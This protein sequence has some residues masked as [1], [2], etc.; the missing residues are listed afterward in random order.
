MYFSVVIP[1]YNRKQTLR[2]TLLALHRQDYSDFEIIV[3]DDGSTDDT[4]EMVHQEF[5]RVHL[6][7]QEQNRGPAAAR[8]LGIHT[9]KGEIIAFTDDDCLPP[10]DWLTR[11]ADGYARYPTAI[12]GGGSLIAPT[13]LLKTDLFAQYEHYIG[14]QVYHADEREYFGSIECPGG[15]TANTSYRRSVLLEIGGFDEEFPVAAGEDADLRSRICNRGYKL[16]YVPI[17]VIHLQEYS[18]QRFRRQCFVRGVGRNYFEERHG[19]GYPSRFKVVLRMVRRV[20]VLPL[21]L[22]RMPDKRL[23]FIKL[24]DGIITCYGQWVG[25]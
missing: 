4:R 7:C 21:D 14:G 23:A 15:G 24:A 3:V 11:L 6:L 22:C 18:W 8:N 13:A 12:G 25:K 5:P 9:A 19:D 10:D 20:S 16:F 1:T 2:Q 17:W